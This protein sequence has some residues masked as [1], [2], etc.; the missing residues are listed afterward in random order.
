MERYRFTSLVQ[1]ELKTGRTH[2]I[3]VHFSFKGHPVFGDGDY[4]GRQK[5]IG[6]FDPSLRIVARE[7]LKLIDRQALH[8]KSL[9]FTHPVSGETMDFAAAPPADFQHLVNRLREDAKHT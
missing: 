3:R 9:S 7:M 5:M 6:G 1:A 8:A 4:G 2:Q